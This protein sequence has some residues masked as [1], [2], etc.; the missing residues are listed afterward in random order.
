MYDSLCE[1]M[2]KCETLYGCTSAGI[3]PVGK[4]CTREE[5]KGVDDNET[6]DSD[7]NTGGP[8]TSDIGISNIQ[9]RQVD[10]TKDTDSKISDLEERHELA[11]KEQ[12]SKA[13]DA[14]ILPKH[15]PD[16]PS[17][18]SVNLIYHP[19]VWANGEFIDDPNYPPPRQ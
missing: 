9:Q 15:L 10:G 5:V 11:E 1:I 14:T 12:G 16:Q 8:Q 4:I 19:M 18:Y 6:H 7:M 2:C 3:A 13:H 17:E